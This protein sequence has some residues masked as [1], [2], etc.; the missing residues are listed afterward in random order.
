MIERAAYELLASYCYPPATGGFVIRSIS[1]QK[2]METFD[3]GQGGMVEPIAG[4]NLVLS[5]RQY[6]FCW[7]R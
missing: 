1:V 7:L 4:A 3:G 2:E 5:T 6:V